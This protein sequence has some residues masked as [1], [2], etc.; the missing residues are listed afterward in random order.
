MMYKTVYKYCKL[1]GTGAGVVEVD[2]RAWS[3][4]VP[5]PETAL[6]KADAAS[7]KAPSITDLKFLGILLFMTKVRSD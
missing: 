5:V 3:L 6:Y 4:D 2:V 1:T 7:A